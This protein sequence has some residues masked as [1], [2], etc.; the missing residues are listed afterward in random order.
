MWIV[1]PEL[2]TN[3]AAEQAI[4]SAVLFRNITFGNMTKR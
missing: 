4:R 1:K 2:L 3:N